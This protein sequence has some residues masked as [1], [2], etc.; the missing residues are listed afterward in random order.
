VCCAHL[1]YGLRY[2]KEGF[3]WETMTKRG[4]KAPAWFENHTELLPT[5]YFYIEAFW[6]L[7]SDRQLGMSVGP[8]PWSVI[9]EYGTAKGLDC[10]NIEAL[11]IVVRCMDQVFLRFMREEQER[12]EKAA[13]SK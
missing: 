4:R 13:N 9:Q 5:E 7:N 6:S 10:G 3:Q 8:I 2:E 12:R 1:E 11:H